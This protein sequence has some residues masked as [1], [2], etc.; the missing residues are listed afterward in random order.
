MSKP[1][2][3]PR[4]GMLASL[5]A[6]LAE[7]VVRRGVVRSYQTG[8]LVHSRG[9]PSDGIGIILSG[10]VRFST[11]NAEGRR[12]TTILFGPGE[13]YG[14]LGMFTESPRVSDAHA[15]QPTRLI[16]LSRTRFDGLLEEE[17]KMRD[18][19]LKFISKRLE[20][21]IA[22]LES[23]RRLPLRVRAANL[24]RQIAAKEGKVTRTQESLA[25]ELA[26]SRYA[27]GTALKN[28]QAEGL[29]ET[30]YGRILIPD[31]KALA[32]WV[33]KHQAQHVAGR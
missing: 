28:L 11:V 31:L 15:T 1:D 26:V 7:K 20:L 8:Q 16:A 32:N 24:L 12:I 23:Q 30:R 21:V 27:L 13:L 19:L 4:Q 22:G 14:L 10:Q 5:P 33:E 3:P 2:L 9:D 25:Q 17:P 6:D 18:Y 29:I